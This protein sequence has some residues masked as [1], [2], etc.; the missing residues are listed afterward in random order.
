MTFSDEFVHFI[1]YSFPFKDFKLIRDPGENTC[2]LFIENLPRI[3]NFTSDTGD[4]LLAALTDT[5]NSFEQSM[6]LFSN[7]IE[8]TANRALEEFRV[9]QIGRSNKR[10]RRFDPLTLG[11]V[12]AIAVTAFGLYTVTEIAIG[13]HE[14][15]QLFDHVSQLEKDVKTLAKSI[16]VLGESFVGFSEEVS[17]AFIAYDKKLNMLKNFTMMQS[18]QTNEALKNVTQFLDDKTIITAIMST[19]NDYR[20]SQSNILQNN[21]IIL[22]D[23]L[24]QYERIF[25]S[26]QN[27]KL[28]HLLM[29]W[30]RLSNL[31]KYIQDQYPRQFQLAINEANKDLYYSLPLVSYSIDPITNDIYISLRI[32]LTRE[33]APR[34]YSIYK[35][36]S[37][38]FSCQNE[39]CFNTNGD[40]KTIYF[41]LTDKLWLTHPMTGELMEEITADSITCSYEQHREV[42]FTFNRNAMT[43]PTEC[44]K[45]VHEFNT[46][47][48]L[49]SCTLK[50]RPSSEYKPIYIGL[51]KYII[52]KNVVP[53]YNI[54]C[55]G[56]NPV[57]V[58]VKEWAE[59]IQLEK[60]CDVFLISI[61]KML[62]GPYADIL[63]S[64]ETE[65]IIPFH[66]EILNTIDAASN[67]SQLEFDDLG[68]ERPELPGYQ[69][70]RP[71]EHPIT[72]DWD[73]NTISRFSKYVHSMTRNVS[74]ALKDVE[75]VIQRKT[76]SFS[77]KGMIN[78]LTSIT[79]LLMTTILVFSAFS[80]SRI[81][82]PAGLVTVIIPR[83]VGASSIF[84]LAQEYIPVDFQTIIDLTVMIVL[85]LLLVAIIHI[86]FFRKTFILTSYGRAKEKPVQYSGWDLRL[87]ITF[88]RIKL[89]SVTMEDIYLSFPIDVFP[90]I[91]VKDMKIVDIF[92]R[93][94]TYRKNGDLYF[95]ILERVPLHAMNGGNRLHEA[96][97]TVKFRVDNIRFHYEPLPSA[98]TGIAAGKVILSL[99]RD[100]STFT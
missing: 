58:Q 91:Q 36:E 95:R 4:T 43:P 6:K 39:N 52:H 93:W 59:I 7:Q 56:R 13:R 75:A 65:V 48:I 71:E 85:L 12:A 38:P 41:K 28:S 45:A 51:D 27:G 97:Q 18:Q 69:P 42:C 50:P 30:T 16:K 61:N 24:N 32:P 8:E 64:K 80:Y 20:L 37:S 86:T 47:K 82:I 44:S 76:S 57:R 79:S 46:S 68:I 67:R 49:R 66:A 10:K 1:K 9:R 100:S 33:K 53:D 23:G 78:T 26:L 90:L 73:T 96:W 22:L 14:R 89:C 54:L 81:L 21:L 15:K 11:V 98:F 87:N 92:F 2:L 94:E 70:F 72:L 19:F 3:R 83:R 99:R 88:T 5:C 35:P 31:L 77:F 60:N 29:P 40:P 84:G 63:K 62:Y 55:H 25:E 74:S 34:V 17:E